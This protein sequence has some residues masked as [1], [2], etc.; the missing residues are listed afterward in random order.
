MMSPS[1]PLESSD[2]WSLFVVLDDHRQN[3]KNAHKNNINLVF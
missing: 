1:Q 2:I 3:N